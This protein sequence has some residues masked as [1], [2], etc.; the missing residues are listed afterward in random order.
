MKSL[1]DLARSY[2]KSFLTKLGVYVAFWDQRRPVGKF[3][4]WGT[5]DKGVLY[6]GSAL[7]KGEM[8][9]EGEL[10]ACEGALKRLVATE[11]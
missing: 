11:K 5:G 4:I 8:I 1:L 3:R 9:K 7:R 2:F 6:I 10:R